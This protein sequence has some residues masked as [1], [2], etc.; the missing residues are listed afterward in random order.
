MFLLEFWWL[1]LWFCAPGTIKLLKKSTKKYGG[2]AKSRAELAYI[3]AYAIIF[4]P[5]GFFISLLSQ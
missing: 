5:F 4:G 3:Y 2:D 1:A